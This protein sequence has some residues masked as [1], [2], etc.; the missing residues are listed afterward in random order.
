MKISGRRHRGRP[1]TR[2]IDH[3]K[4]DVERRGRDW[5]VEEMQEWADR[6]SLRLLCKS[7][8]TS[9]ETT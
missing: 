9:V 4:R 3:V 1:C 6:D 7:R 5:R 8:P 2:W